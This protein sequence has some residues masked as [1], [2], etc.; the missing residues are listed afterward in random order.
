MEMPHCSLIVPTRTFAGH[1]W[2]RS[3]NRRCK[4]KKTLRDNRKFGAEISVH[5]ALMSVTAGEQAMGQMCAKCGEQVYGVLC[6]SSMQEPLHWTCAGCPTAEKN[7]NCS[8]STAARAQEEEKEKQENEEERVFKRVLLKRILRQNTG[9]IGSKGL[10]GAMGKASAT[11]VEQTK[12]C[13]AEETV[14]V[15]RCFGNRT[16]RDT[17]RVP[18]RNLKVSTSF[19]LLRKCFALACLYLSQDACVMERKSA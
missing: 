19:T 9:R 10:D 13:D 17:S 3:W 18:T 16:G 12:A 14:L 1:N 11:T 7:S 2:K 6:R 5:W 8:G 4:V 15:P